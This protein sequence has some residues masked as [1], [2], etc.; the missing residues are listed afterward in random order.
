MTRRVLFL[1]SDTGGGHRAAAEAIRA[2]LERRY[3]QQYTCALVD[4][5]RRYTPFPTR[6]M[7][8]L[9]PHWVNWAGPTWGF[10]YHFANTARRG[11]VV[12]AVL[13]RLWQGGLRQ[14][15]RDHPADV[16][17]VAH[18]L[19]SRP[20][21]R[22]YQ[23]T[24]A[25]RPPF[26]T[27]I[28][29]LVSTHAFWYEKDV[30]RC[31]VPTQAALS[32]GHLFGLS[33]DQLRLTGLPVHPDFIDALR[34]KPDARRRLGWD[35]SRPVV[36][37]V[38]GG[39]GM[40][41]LG[42]IARALDHQRLTARLVIVAGRNRRLYRRLQSADWQQSTTVYPFVSNMSQLMAAAD[43][44]ITK[45]GPA[46]I[47]EACVAGLPMILSGAIPGQEAGNVSYVVENGAG[48]FAP[49]PAHVAEI[50]AE[51]LSADPD[52][53]AR[54]AAQ[55]RALARPDAAYVIAEEIHRQAH[56][57]PLRTPLADRLRSRPGLRPSP[58]DGWL[59]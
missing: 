51:W 6:Y 21:M 1:M 14:L 31:L 25:H 16:V 2:A 53:L 35:P 37:L 44:L 8:E 49:Q 47:G 33:A 17:V 41:S 57:P 43:I 7:P 30:E 9:Y 24:L 12:M 5:Y 27:L 28:T 42:A 59:I 23:Q 36:L 48:V 46:T 29:D 10:S 55:A 19:F 11:R 20:V 40:G 56:R 32:R 18:A 38:G 50:A 34:P 13:Q 3:P 4:V 39:D 52:A 22:A 45:A 54:R 26:V 15:V 58:E